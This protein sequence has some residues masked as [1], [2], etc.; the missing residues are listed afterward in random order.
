M[1][2]FSPRRGRRPPCVDGTLLLLLPPCVR[3]AP[4]HVLSVY[5]LRPL[6]RLAASDWQSSW[7]A[8]EGVDPLSAAGAGEG[9]G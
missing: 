1:A 6:T 4:V 5:M 9:G 2:F 3:V 7:I 8:A